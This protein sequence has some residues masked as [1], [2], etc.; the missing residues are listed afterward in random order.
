M[1]LNWSELCSLYAVSLSPARVSGVSPCAPTG[2]M[3]FSTGTPEEAAEGPCRSP[4]QPPVQSEVAIGRRWR[5][6]FT[7]VLENSAGP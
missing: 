5:R 3:I 7:G 2:Q 1:P 4:F 6:S